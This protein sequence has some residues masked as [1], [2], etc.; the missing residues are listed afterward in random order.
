M[1]RFQSMFLSN[2][3]PLLWQDALADVRLTIRVGMLRDAGMKPGAIAE[4]VG[5]EL[6]EVQAAVRRLD[7]VRETADL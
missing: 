3:Y 2:L 6:H 7:R 1:P 5:A 4:E